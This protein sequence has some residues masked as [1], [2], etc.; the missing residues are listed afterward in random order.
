MLDKNRN[1]PI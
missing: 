1:N